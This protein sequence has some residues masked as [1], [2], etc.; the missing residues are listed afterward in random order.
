MYV[1]IYM[2]TKEKWNIKPKLIE[3]LSKVLS[4]NNMRT[5]IPFLKFEPKA[6]VTVL[7]CRKVKLNTARDEKKFTYD[8][9][10]SSKRPQRE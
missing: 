7:I 3:N 2:C 6:R 9:T 5:S 10:K 4:Y 1:H 8:H